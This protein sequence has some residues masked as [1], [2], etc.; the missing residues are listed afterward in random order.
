MTRTEVIERIAHSDIKWA[1]GQ[2][3]AQNWVPRRRNS[4]KYSFRYK[5]R[6]YPPKYLIMLAGKHATGEMLTPDDHGGGEHDSNRVLREI[7][8]KGGRIVNQ[9]SR[10][11]EQ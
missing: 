8:V 10:W 2:I 5:G 11:P 4:T 1:I 3:N 6:D 7:G 9:P